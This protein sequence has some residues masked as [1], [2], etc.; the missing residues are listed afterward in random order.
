MSLRDNILLGA[1]FIEDR[2]WEVVE[3]C[4]LLRDLDVSWSPP[5][6]PPGPQPTPP[7]HPHPH[8]HVHPIL[9]IL[10][11]GDRTEIG[12]RGVNLSGGQQQRV[13][14]ARAVYLLDADIYLLDDVLSAVDAHVG[15]AIWQQCILDL[16]RGK[17]KATVVMVSHNQSLCL[18]DA[19]WVVLL[20]SKPLIQD[21]RVVASGSNNSLGSLEAEGGRRSRPSGVIRWQG[22]PS[23]LAAYAGAEERADVDPAAVL[24]ASH[25][26]A[27]GGGGGGDGHDEGGAGAAGGTKGHG[28]DKAAMLQRVRSKS[29]ATT[30]RVKS[31]DGKLNVGQ[32]TKAEARKK[33]SIAGRLYKG[34]FRSAGGPCF[35]FMWFFL[36]FGVQGMY[37]VTNLGG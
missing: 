32:L 21:G 23:D 17:R 36:G 34:Y 30:G 5:P 1:P 6:P 24:L 15:A 26:A 9:K 11:A 27:P 18:K 22:K 33:G 10:P 29:E 14:L 3:A 16:L 35:T 31:E 25:L 7:A 2:Y 13:S 20:G 8:P 19:D 37:Y 4:Q 12:E 28:D